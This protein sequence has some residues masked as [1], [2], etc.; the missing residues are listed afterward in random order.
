MIN[1]RI[2]ISKTWRSEIPRLI[3]FF[4]S[5]ISA[6]ILTE[7]FP[8]SIVRGP[9]FT[10]GDSTVFLSLPLYWLTPLT[11]LF[12]LIAKIYNVRYY[13]DSQGI[14][15]WDGILSI[16]QVIT[17]VRHEDIRS[18]ETDQSLLERFLD[19]G[20]VAVGTAATSGIEIALRGVDSPKKLQQFLQAE[21][22]EVKKTS[23]APS[24]PTREQ[25]NE[26]S[27]GV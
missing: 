27:A 23:Q 10:L 20:T 9:I 22:D 12:E 17:R 1:G 6:P 4:V 3:V 14:E 25:Q 5:I 15:S 2:I 21:R 13:I 26:V 16:R 24:Q 19:I 18:I 11:A 8:G 7:I